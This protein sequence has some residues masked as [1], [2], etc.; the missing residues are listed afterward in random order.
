MTYICI[1][2]HICTSW[3]IVCMFTSLP[4]T[5]EIRMYITKTKGFPRSSV[6]KDSAC[7]SGDL[8]SISG[9]G[10][11]SGEENGNPLQYSCLENPMD[12]GIWWATVHVV[13]KS[14]TRLKQLNTHT[15]L[16]LFICK[17]S[18]KCFM[19]Q[20]LKQFK[21]VL[22]LQEEVFLFL[23]FSRDKISEIYLIGK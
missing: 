19:I 23:V 7:N 15:C 20:S 4:N 13:A 8:D 10:R 3:H 5:F 11:S 21:L 18:V 2:T 16:L 6:G 12:R 9:S 17:T 14:R 1:F 22:N